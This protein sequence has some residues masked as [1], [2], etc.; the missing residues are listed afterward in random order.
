MTCGTES[1]SAV[2]FGQAPQF[3]SAFEPFRS[4]PPGFSFSVV[5]N[6]NRSRR[7]PTSGSR[8]EANRCTRRCGGQWA[9][10]TGFIS[11]L[12]ISH[13]TGMDQR[14]IDSMPRG[15]RLPHAGKRVG[16]VIRI[17]FAEGGLGSSPQ[18]ATAVAEL[19]ASITEGAMRSGARCDEVQIDYDCP[20]SKLGLYAKFLADLKAACGNVTVAFTA[21]PSWL[22]N[23]NF[24]ELARTSGN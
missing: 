4:A 17:P 14:F 22:G 11:T 6:R 19:I 21:L 13:G 7:R 3:D 8:F 15:W 24:K 18:A 16:T 12:P 23:P 20:T 2:V 5:Q 9:S 10:W 1:K